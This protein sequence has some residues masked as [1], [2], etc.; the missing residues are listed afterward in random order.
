[1]DFFGAKQKTSGSNSFTLLYL[2]E[3]LFSPTPVLFI[4]EVTKHGKA[5]EQME[6][7]PPRVQ[8]GRWIKNPEQ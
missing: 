4:F 6:L 1:M 2:L 3:D 7:P 8:E 5:S